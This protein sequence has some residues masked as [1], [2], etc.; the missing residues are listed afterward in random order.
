MILQEESSPK[1]TPFQRL[2]FRNP[3]DPMLLFGKVCRRIDDYF[4]RRGAVY[5]PG[6]KESLYDAAE[7]LL[8]GTQGEIIAIPILPGGGKSTLIRSLLEVLSE[9]FRQDSLPAQKIGGVV[10]VVQKSSEG[11]ELEDLCN[12][13]LDQPVALLLESANDFNLGRGGCINGNASSFSQCGKGACPDYADCPLMHLWD[14]IG[15]VPILILLHARYAAYLED[16]SPFLHWQC[17]SEER[18]R[19]LLLVD[20][21]PDLFRT[22]QISLQILNEAETQ[23]DAECRNYSP[24]GRAKCEMLYQ[25]RRQ[26]RTPFFALRKQL[27]RRPNK[28][29]ILSPKEL[30]AEGFNR[31]D[32]ADYWKKLEE[33]L[34]GSKAGRIV[35]ALLTAKYVLFSTR[36]V[37]TLSIPSLR[38]L[39]GENQPATFLF[40]GTATIAPEVIRNPEIHTRKTTWTEDFSRLQVFIQRGDAFS[41]S[42][43][44]FAKKRNQDAAILWLREALAKLII[45]NPKVLLVTYQ[46][47]AGLLWNA[48]EEFHDHLIPYIDGEGKPQPKLP[49]FGGMNGSNLYQEA[50]CVICLGLHRFEPA[51]YLWRAVALDNEGKILQAIQMQLASSNHKYRDLEQLPEVLDIQDATLADDLI[52]LI[53]RCALRRHGETQQI[54][55]WLFQPPNGVLARLAEFFP[56]ACFKDVKAVPESCRTA[57]T[58][59]RQYKGSSTHAA[60]LLTWLTSQWD[61][62]EITPKEIREHIN[63]TMKQFKEAKKNADVKTFF[64]S[65]VETSGSGSNTIYRRKHDAP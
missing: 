64:A 28:S 38:K 21:L 12:Q 65:C 19:T 4:Q 50:T 59:G 1:V 36:N 13:N 24:R 56:G 45:Y 34:P 9:E 39:S 30:E 27:Y 2:Q 11:H 31:D 5:L 16:M 14:R 22:N 15:E 42:K 7:A 32:L 37:D 53:F 49:Y 20:E 55:V 10:V 25:W 23:L 57:M 51:E 40:S 52:Q 17:G 3:D 43:T 61:G 62:K 8:S 54:T 48:L 58:T 18:T 6:Q 46:R 60:I 26:I 47:I 29:G 33:Y 41:T 44:A 63:L 35:H